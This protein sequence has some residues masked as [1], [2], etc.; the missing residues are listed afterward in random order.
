MSLLISTYGIGPVYESENVEHHEQMRPAVHIKDRI[1][2]L[3]A[4]VLAFLGQQNISFSTVS[5]KQLIQQEC[6]IQ[7]KILEL[8]RKKGHFEIVLKCH[9]K[10]IIPC[11]MLKLFNPFLANVPILYPLNTPENHRFSG[12]FRGYKM[13]TLARNGLNKKN[14]MK[15]IMSASLK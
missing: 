15:Q 6:C 4:M 2:N 10:R 12:V 5:S 9:S 3:E 14:K 8:L 13:E 1:S 11:Y 7:D